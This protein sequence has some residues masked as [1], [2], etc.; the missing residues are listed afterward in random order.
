MPSPGGPTPLRLPIEDSY[1]ELL[2]DT[3]DHLDLPARGQFLQRYIRA[4]THLDLRE[5]QCVQLWDDVLTRRR[6]LS[7]HL[8]RQVA[9][10]T[11]LMD[12]LEWPTPNV[13]NSLS[14]RDGKGARPLSC[15]MVC[16]S[17]RRP[18]NTL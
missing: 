17:A 12:V 4:I 9:L 3:L 18:V 11:A 16:R 5:N 14:L 2:A 15:L 8:G 13:S 7:V 6:E 1:L 10:K